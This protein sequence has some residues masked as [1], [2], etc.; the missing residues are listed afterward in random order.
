MYQLGVARSNLPCGPAHDRITDDPLEDTSRTPVLHPCLAPCTHT[1]RR[2]TVTAFLTPLT[3]SVAVWPGVRPNSRTLLDQLTSSASDWFSCWV[4][5]WATGLTGGEGNSQRQTRTHTHRPGE[6]GGHS[7]I[8]YRTATERF[9]LTA[10]R[11][12]HRYSGQT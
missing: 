6:G 3:T 11:V 10:R 1:R 12:Y 8:G 9:S 4:D 7:F 2:L 5:D